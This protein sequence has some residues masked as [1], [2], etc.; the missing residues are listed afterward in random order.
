[1]GGGRGLGIFIPESLC[2][3]EQVLYQGSQEGLLVEDAAPE[4]EARPG[5]LTGAQHF[6]PAPTPDGSLGLLIVPPAWFP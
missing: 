4:D 6:R 5:D 3:Q 1:M 2:W